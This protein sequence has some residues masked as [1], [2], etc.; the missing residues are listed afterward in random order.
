MSTCHSRHVSQTGELGMRSFGNDK[1][2]TRMIDSRFMMPGHITYDNIN[3]AS[4][5]VDS[6]KR[7]R[8]I[9]DRHS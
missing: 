2:L 8:E 3:I 7:L 1:A 4:P 6:I 9:E 5:S